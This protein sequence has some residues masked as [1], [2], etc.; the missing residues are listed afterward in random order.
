MH[1]RKQAL[2]A[3]S[4]YSLTVQENECRKSR[5]NREEL[6]GQRSLAWHK[7]AFHLIW[8]ES[9]GASKGEAEII[10]LHLVKEDEVSISL[11]FPLQKISQTVQC[12]L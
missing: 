3:R 2:L 11:P 9:D 10:T 6:S 1:K 12:T 7:K 4:L 8:R 5:V